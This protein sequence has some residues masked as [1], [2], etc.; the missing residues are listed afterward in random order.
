M[1]LSWFS[2]DPRQRYQKIPSHP[3]EI[4]SGLLLDGG[5]S[6]DEDLVSPRV[7]LDGEVTGERDQ[8]DRSH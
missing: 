5:L 1:V 3:D 6:E 8:V 4:V 7:V 2:S